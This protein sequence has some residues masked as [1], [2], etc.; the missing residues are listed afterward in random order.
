MLTQTGQPK[1]SSRLDKLR[2]KTPAAKSNRSRPRGQNVEELVR[3]SEEKRLLVRTLPVRRE[4]LSDL[5]NTKPDRVRW[6]REKWHGRIREEAL[7]DLIELGEELR[8]VWKRPRIDGAEKILDRWLAWR[9]LAATFRKYKESEIERPD[10]VKA[11]DYLP[12]ECSI[13]AG[14]LVPNWVHLRAM[15]IQGVLEHW[16]HFR[17]C[18]NADCA[19]PYFIAKRKDQTICDAEICKAEKQRAHAL[20]WWHKNRGKT[21]DPQK[22]SA[23]KRIGRGRIGHEK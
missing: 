3:S 7:R 2:S 13:G 10:A 22:H 12:F 21:S 8:V 5:A 18:A 11:R 4:L 14:R 23:G 15:L 6:F 1:F 19:A 16:K 9:P 20:K 17:I